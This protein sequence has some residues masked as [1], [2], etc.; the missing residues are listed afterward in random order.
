MRFSKTN[1]SSFS[2]FYVLFFAISVMFAVSR[3]G[4]L[5]TNKGKI[6]ESQFAV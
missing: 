2:L 5:L 3:Q 4:I 6:F 1:S